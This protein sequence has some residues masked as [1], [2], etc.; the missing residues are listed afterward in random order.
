MYYYSRFL[1]IISTYSIFKCYSTLIPQL[2]RKFAPELPGDFISL[3]YFLIYISIHYSA[4]CYFLGNLLTLYETR[5][6]LH[7]SSILPN[8]SCSFW[9]NRMEWVLLLSLVFHEDMLLKCGPGHGFTSIYPPIAPYSGCCNSSHCATWWLLPTYRAL[10]LSKAL[11]PELE[12]S[13]HPA[14]NVLNECALTIHPG[15]VVGWLDSEA[16]YLSQSFTWNFPP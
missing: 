8:P 9:V 6:A 5:K 15:A 12:H 3:H 16:V 4:E 7:S 1:V 14:S 13:H 10:F 11:F 2:L